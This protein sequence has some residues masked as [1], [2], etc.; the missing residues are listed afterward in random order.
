MGW[1]LHKPSTPRHDSR[2]S[3]LPGG[4]CEDWAGSTF[5][6]ESSWRGFLS[7]RSSVDHRDGVT[8]RFTHECSVNGDLDVCTTNSLDVDAG[9]VGPSNTMASPGAGGSE[10]VSGPRDSRGRLHVARPTTEERFGRI[11]VGSNGFRILVSPHGSMKARGPRSVSDQAIG[12][13]LR[14]RNAAPNVWP[15]GPRRSGRSP[16]DVVIDSRTG[17]IAQEVEL[18]SPSILK[19]PNDVGWEFLTP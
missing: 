13:R 12:R 2:F 10:A 17:G 5:V 16:G 8:V 9:H 6:P 15:A 11:G 19:G 1:K 14:R 18:D 4:F 3:V 7:S